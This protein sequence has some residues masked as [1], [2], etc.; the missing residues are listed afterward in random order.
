M[1]ISIQLL[2]EP[3]HIPAKLDSGLP[4]DHTLHA[5][6]P[7]P[8][9]TIYLIT[10]Y[11]FHYVLVSGVLRD[12]TCAFVDRKRFF[13]E[14]NYGGRVIFHQHKNDAQLGVPTN[15]VVKLSL[16]YL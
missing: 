3:H 2:S 6:L 5:I 16:N 10:R 14:A 9:S 13:V 1:N 12:Y 4:L 11:T 7:T 15:R 8:K